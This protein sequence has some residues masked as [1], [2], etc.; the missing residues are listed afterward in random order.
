MGIST[1][2]KHAFYFIYQTELEN[3]LSEHELD[4]VFLGKFDGIPMV[5]PD[6]AQD[7][8]W[9]SLEDVK[10]EIQTDP[11]Q[12]TFWFKYI[13][14]HFTEKITPDFYEGL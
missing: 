11:S 8:R 10:S 9:V 13:I 2:L 7:F 12:F 6:E 3:N 5:N 14:E 1:R 4:H